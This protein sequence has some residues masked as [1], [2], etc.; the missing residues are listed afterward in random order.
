MLTAAFLLHPYPNVRAEEGD[1]HARQVKLSVT[2]PGSN[3]NPKKMLDN[4]EYTYA[5]A[6]KP[7]ELIISSDEA[8]KSIYLKFEKNYNWIIKLPDGQTIK[9][10]KEDFI[11][12]YL[13][14]D[15]A[16]TSF[17]LSLPL[18]CAVTDIYA[19]TDGQPPEWVQI[20]QPPCDRADLM[21]MPTHADDEYLWFGGT[22]PYY[23]GELGY[24]VQVVY[25]TNHNNATY[26]NHERLNSLWTV[27]VRHYPVIS[28]FT[29]VKETK[30]GEYEA[31]RIFGYKKVMAFQVEVLRRFKP[32][33]VIAHDYNGEYGHGA[34]KLNA[35]TLLKALP[36]T[37]NASEYPK[38]AEKYGTCKI[39]KCY[40]HL[41][42]ENPIEVSWSDKTLSKF[43]GKTALEM[44]AEGYKCNVSQ[45]LRVK[46]KESGAYDCRKFGLAYT[47]VGYDT[48]GV[49]DFFENVDWSGKKGRVDDS[50]SEPQT[51][52]T[53]SVSTADH[54]RE[55]RPVS[56]S[57]QDS[58][59]ARS[60]LLLIA[61]A[62]AVVFI[63]AVCAMLMRFRK[64]S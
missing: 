17:R 40:L 49:N 14:F 53:E 6:Y 19:F 33:V 39:Q 54:S 5:F 24:E 25:L 20:W 16:I 47:N 31:G 13:T 32:R 48:P 37:D 23:A 26:R 15:Q 3:F 35:R 55:D 50:S 42:K 52:V 30:R 58:M 38:S 8:F 34:H 18:Y 61:V 44:A 29:D 63:A 59:K 46:M 27:G 62:A 28:S 51:E 56:P 43:G 11:H 22:L 60:W 2:S 4:D 7:T 41:W 1:S 64:R 57:D 10:E 12:K 9:P 21:L 36:L 45:K